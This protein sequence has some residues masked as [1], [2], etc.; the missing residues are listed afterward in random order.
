MRTILLAA[1][2]ALLAAAPPIAAKSVPAAT[3]TAADRAEIQL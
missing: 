3:I 1:A 2:A